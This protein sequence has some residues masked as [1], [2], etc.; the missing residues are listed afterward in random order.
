VNG[1]DCDIFTITLSGSPAD[2][3]NLVL[4]IQVGWKLGANDYDVYV[5]K[6]DV[7]GPVVASSTDGIPGVSES[8]VINPNAMG[9]GS[10]LFM[11]WIRQ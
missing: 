1:V 4:S 11:W 8:I 9:L 10:T 6:G 5:H 2:Y 7:T 3:A